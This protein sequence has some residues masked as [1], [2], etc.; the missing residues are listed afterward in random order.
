[1]SH[2]TD[3]LPVFPDPQ[4]HR[5]GVTVSMV[6]LTL[7][8]DL[9]I[10]EWLEIVTRM[11]RYGNAYRFC[12]GDALTFGRRVYGEMYSQAEDETGMDYGRLSNY[13]YVAE[14]V[15]LSLR[16]ENLSWSHHYAVARLNPIEQA[17]WLRDAAEGVWTVS[18]LRLN[19]EEKHGPARKPKQA[20]EA[21][22]DPG[23]DVFTAE[24]EA[25]ERERTAVLPVDGVDGLD[26][27]EPKAGDCCPTCGRVYTEEASRD[28]LGKDRRPAFPVP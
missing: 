28:A 8:D 15:P 14:R 4:I 23:Y 7:P 11:E 27:W 18:L 19:I 22:T 17:K 21:R 12:I 13:R 5:E 9:P 1:M 6:G 16:N 10:A 20:A 26:G 2:I 3:L 24:A 25:E